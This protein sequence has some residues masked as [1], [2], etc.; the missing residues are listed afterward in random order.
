MVECKLDVLE[1]RFTPV[2]ITLHI[3]LIP[4]GD[5]LFD[6]HMAETGKKLNSVVNYANAT[7][8]VRTAPIRGAH[9][10]SKDKGASP[11]EGGMYG[12]NAIPLEDQLVKE[13]NARSL[14]MLQQRLSSAK[15][16]KNRAEI[17]QAETHL[18]Y[19][20]ENLARKKK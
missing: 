18:K 9:E 4:G 12:K 16:S 17:R 13:K 14:K 5:G 19:F 10:L 6:M 20:E 15:A 2:R 3:E 11:Q 1:S 8:G 7:F